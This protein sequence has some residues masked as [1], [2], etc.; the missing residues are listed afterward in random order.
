MVEPFRVGFVPGVSPGKWLRTWADRLPDAP[1]APVPVDVAEQREILLTA[2][3][4]V[5]L[6]R[7]P[8]DRTGLHVIP[9]YAEVPVVVAAKDHPI[10]AFDEL[11][12]ADLAAEHLLQDTADVPEW[13]AVAD[14]VRDGTR[15]DPSPMTVAQAIEVAASG[16]GIV[17]V[18][19][20]LARLHHRKDVLHR[21]VAGVMPSQVGLAW[22]V[23]NEDPRMETFIG[24]VRGR[25][26]R[27]SRDASSG[28]AADAAG[29]GGRRA[30]G[31]A[32]RKAGG[33]GTTGARGAPGR[34]TS[35]TGRPG[36]PTGHGRGPRGRRG[37]R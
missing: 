16:S 20:S 25:T 28:D 12:V 13:T 30:R 15:L 17:I 18:P 36:G 27:S 22:L 9:L 2:G 31:D 32:G 35:G 29:D 3:V 10:A 37:R 6:V 33:R 8:I 4:D 34:R 19:M 23:D 5:A 26:E 21:P 14:E 24:I 7:L 11:D 1:L